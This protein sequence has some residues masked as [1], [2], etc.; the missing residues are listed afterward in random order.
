M[1][2]SAVVVPLALVLLLAQACVGNETEKPLLIIYC[3]TTPEYGQELQRL[4]EADGQ[5]DADIL[6]LQDPEVFRLAVHFPTVR[7]VV[8]SL[9]LSLSQN[10]GASLEWFFSEGGGLVGLGFAGATMTTGNAS[11]NVF[12]IFANGYVSGSYD[13]ESK[14]YTMSHLKQDEDYISEGVMSFTVSTHKLVLSRNLSTNDY[15]PKVPQAGIYKVLFREAS[16]GAPSV[17]KYDHS[18]VSVTFACFGGDDLP[19]GFNYYGRFAERAEFKTLFTRAVQ[20][21][22]FNERKYEK[23]MKESSDHFADQ[24]EELR[25]LMEGARKI[26]ARAGQRRL[27]TAIVTITLAG[28]AI[29]LV[30]RATFR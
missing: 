8:V 9:A 3:P 7:V 14:T 13:L 2:Q 25:S 27:A 19:R 24:E 16:T 1:I 20:W 22:W 12:P 17:V 10:I 15:L 6:L 30:Y 4:I 29:A 23:S 18:G 21:V 5:V 28:F 26:E 11:Q